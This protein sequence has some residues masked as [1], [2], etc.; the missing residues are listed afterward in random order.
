M[1]KLI[2]VGGLGLGLTLAFPILGLAVL[3]AAVTVGIVRS[4]FTG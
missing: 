4:V 3:A 1:H 2:F